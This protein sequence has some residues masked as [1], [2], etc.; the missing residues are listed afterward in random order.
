LIL[1]TL[2][3]LQEISFVVTLADLAIVTALFL[4]T[5][6][7]LT[8]TRRRRKHHRTVTNTSWRRLREIVRRRDKE[9]CYYCN[10]TVSNGHVDHLVPLSRGGSDDLSNLVWA[11]PSC[12]AAKSDMTAKEF[13]EA[14]SKCSPPE[15]KQQE[16]ITP[17]LG[18]GEEPSAIIAATIRTW[19]AS[20][21]SKN[22]ICRRTWGY[23]DGVVWAILERVLAGEL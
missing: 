20:G 17:L 8:A 7:V 6:I 10:E 18:A 23:K 13:W 11:C 4:P 12:N 22:E 1:D 15:L 14:S 21:V 3:V 16:P 19:H 2:A 9:R 5:L